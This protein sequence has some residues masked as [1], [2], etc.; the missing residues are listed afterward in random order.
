MNPPCVSDALCRN[1]EERGWWGQQWG[2]GERER[3]WSETHAQEPQAR[4]P[5]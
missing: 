2:T 5:T 4:E 3:R 1:R